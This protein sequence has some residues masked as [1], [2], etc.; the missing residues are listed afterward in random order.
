[1]VLAGLLSQVLL[2]RRHNWFV[3]GDG[4]ANCALAWC[5]DVAL[6]N[7][8]RNVMVSTIHDSAQDDGCNITHQSD[9]FK[10]GLTTRLSFVI[11]TNREH[12]RRFLVSIN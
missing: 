12:Q 7:R 3:I 10:D 2:R 8:T 9:A 5:E 11:V 4:S 1:M 6:G